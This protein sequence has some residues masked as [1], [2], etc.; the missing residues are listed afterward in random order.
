[1][2]S[3]AL[4][5]MISGS[6]IANTVTTGA[7]MTSFAR[8]GGVTHSGSAS[9]TR[10][11]ASSAGSA[12]RAKAARGWPPPP[13]VRC[14]AR[15]TST[16]ASARA[17]TSVL[18]CMRATT[19]AASA[20]V[21]SSRSPATAAAFGWYA[22]PT[23]RPMA[24]RRPSTVRTSASWSI[25]SRASRSSGGVPSLRKRRTRSRLAPCVSSQAAA[26]WSSGRTWS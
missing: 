21:A 18:P 7:L 13:S 8:T 4:F 3:S 10:A 12:V 23:S 9:R 5:G 24:M 16:K 11:S 2:F 19:I 15:A 25:R 17:N 6:S 26:R 1:M 14:S 22:S 20:A